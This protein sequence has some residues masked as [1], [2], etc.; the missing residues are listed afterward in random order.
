MNNLATFP[1]ESKYL[2]V[3]GINMHYVEEDEG[4]PILL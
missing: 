4:N 2:E 3:N 1:S